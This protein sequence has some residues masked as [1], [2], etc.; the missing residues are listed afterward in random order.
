[1]GS[2]YFALHTSGCIN[3]ACMYM[4]VFIP[5]SQEQVIFNSYYIITN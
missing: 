1:M 4:Y 5:T 2:M 3:E